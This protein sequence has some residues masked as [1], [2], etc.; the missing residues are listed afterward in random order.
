MLDVA[1]VG[2]AEGLTGK[3]WDEKSSC[4]EERDGVVLL[5]RSARFGVG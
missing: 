2:V 1:L 3:L 4:P 5:R